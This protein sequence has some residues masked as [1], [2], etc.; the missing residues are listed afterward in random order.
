MKRTIY[1]VAV[2]PEEAFNLPQYRGFETKQ[3]AAKHLLKLQKRAP[4][5]YWKDRIFKVSVIVESQ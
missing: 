4:D 5:I 3:K 1:V 2:S